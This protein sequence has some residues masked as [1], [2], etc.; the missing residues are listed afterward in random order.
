MEWERLEVT[1][2]KLEIPKEHFM[3]RW[4]QQKTETVRPNRSRRAGREGYTEELYKKG[5]NE[6]DNHDG[7]VTYLEPEILE[8]ELKQDL[9]SSTK[10]KASGGDGIPAVISSAEMWCCEIAALSMPANLENS[11]KANRTGKGKF[12]F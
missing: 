9:G 7:V 1:S 8:C 6:P 2:R 3:Q 5:L 10:N 12:S 4:A 11:A